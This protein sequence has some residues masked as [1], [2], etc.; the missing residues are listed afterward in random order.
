VIIEAGQA[1]IRPSLHTAHGELHSIVL[2]SD[3]ARSAKRPTTA[4]IA[5]VVVVSYDSR[6]D[7]RDCV[8]PLAEDPR[9]AVAV[10][11]NASRD[12]SLATVSD[13]P[14]RAI[15]LR[16]NGGFAHGCNRG[17]REGSAPYIVFLNPDARFP[18]NAIKLLIETVEASG[19]TAAAVPRVVSAQGRLD[20]S[21]RRFPRLRTTYAQA[22]FLHRVFPH[23]SWADELIRQPQHYDSEQNV[24]WASGVCLLVRRD[25]LEEI[26]GWDERFF[27]YCED[28]DLCRRLHDSGHE[29][30]YVPRAVVVHRGGASAPRADMLPILAASRLL[31][32]KK[33]LRM[34]AR[35][36]ERCG[37]MLG[38]LTHIV[39]GRG[40]ASM[41]TGHAR[42]FAVAAG[43]RKARL[44]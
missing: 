44:P 15:A 3:K 8:A 19:A 33:H 43:W 36:A 21:L 4:V 11:D 39:A 6:D 30:R 18:P 7:L 29:I 37:I 24:A 41:R 26:D 25:V 38:A 40:G 16:E 20:Y 28:I 17:W 27:M 31:Y 22:L 10:V 13:L 5:D 14:V 34:P 1:W 42:A 32:A 9:F 2:V 12:E 23:A 35:I